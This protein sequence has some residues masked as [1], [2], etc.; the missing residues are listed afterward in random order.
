MSHR[1]L[2][3]FERRALSTP[4]HTQ[5]VSATSWFLDEN[6]RAQG[7][8]RLPGGNQVDGAPPVPVPMNDVDRLRSG[9][10]WQPEAKKWP[11]VASPTF[12]PHEC[13]LRCPGFGPQQVGM[14]TKLLCI[15]GSRESIGSHCCGSRRNKPTAMPRKQIGPWAKKPM[16]GSPRLDDIARASV[17]GATSAAAIP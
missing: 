2:D 4:T 15:S 16:K 12:K 11:V 8:T 7:S 9:H 10:S 14:Q 13:V 3:R 5:S 1:K 6:R 17:R